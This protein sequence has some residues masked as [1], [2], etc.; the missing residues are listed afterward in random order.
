MWTGLNVIRKKLCQGDMVF[1]QEHILI[2]QK[3]SLKSSGVKC[4][5]LYM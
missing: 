1:M 4:H 5:V 3:S 2:F